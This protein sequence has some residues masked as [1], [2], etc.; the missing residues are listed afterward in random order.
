M[1]H[2]GIFVGNPFAVAI[3]DQTCFF[4]DADAGIVVQVNCLNFRSVKNLGVDLFAQLQAV[5]EVAGRNACRVFITDRSGIPACHFTIAGIS[6]GSDDD[7]FGIDSHLTAVSF[8][9]A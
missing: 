4:V 3:E 8:G 2:I 6:A 9:S 7:V 1:I 5:A